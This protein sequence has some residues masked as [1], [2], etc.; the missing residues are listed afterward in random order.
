MRPVARILRRVAIKSRWLCKLVPSAAAPV[1]LTIE[2]DA[3]EAES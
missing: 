2:P 3:F 1:G